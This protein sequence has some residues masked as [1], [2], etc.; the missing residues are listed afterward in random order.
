MI[1]YIQN[2]TQ[3]FAMIIRASFKGEGINFFTPDEYSLQLAYMN[4][5]TGYEIKP[6][7]HCRVDRKTQLTQEVLVIRKG[8][9]RVDFYNDEKVYLASRI[10]NQGDVI[11]LASG[12]HGFKA[13]EEVE[14][15]EVKQGP[16]A[17]DLDKVRFDSQ[18]N[19][20]LNFGEVNDSC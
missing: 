3:T 6:H 5:P 16:F 19:D 7:L 15:I 18:I 20:V 1:E 9:L 2:Q 11:L 12:G 14:V 8:K 13:I 4:R 10:L 17:K